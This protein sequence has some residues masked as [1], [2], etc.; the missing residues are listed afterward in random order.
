MRVTIVSISSGLIFFTSDAAAKVVLIEE[1]VIT[2]EGLYFWYPNGQKAFHYAPSISPRG[3]CYTI[4]NGYIFFGW[5]KGGMDQRD[6]MISRKKIGSGEWETVELPHKN[7]LI[8]PGAKWGESHNTITVGVSTKD[9]TIHIFYD[10]HNDPLKYIVSKKGTA[11][12]SDRDFKKSIF[13]PTRGHLAE[14]EPIRITYPKITENGLGDLIVNYRKGSAIGGNEM[15]HVYNGEQ[16]SR[17]KQVTRGSDQTVPESRKNYAYS[18]A[19]VFANGNVYYSFSVRWRKNKEDG[20]LNEGVYLAK[21]GPTMTDDWEDPSGKRHKLPIEDYAPFLVADPESSGGRGANGGPP[22][23]VS[24]QGDIVLG[25]RGRGS[26]NTYDFMYTRS[27][28]QRKFTE[29]RGSIK[30]GSFWGNR[31]FSVTAAR[32]GKI[33]VRSKTLEESDWKEELEMNTDIRFGSAVSKLVDGMLVLI[34]E[35]RSNQKTDRQKIHCY[36]FKIGEPKKVLPDIARIKRVLTNR[37]DGAKIEVELIDVQQGM[38]I[39][40]A[41]DRQFEIP[42]AVLCDEDIEFLKQWMAEKAP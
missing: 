13:E 14:G 4:A 32:D 7:T 15:V 27:A 35:D 24:E 38:L 11:F 22:L 39:C 6:L 33:T 42:V 9:D 8:G 26:A 18:P 10:H 25:F 40:F 23:A 20:V 2:N 41:K 36:A 29:S 19:P 3:D 34:V 28:G 30:I 31:M 12:I 16:W 37:E 21:C 17:A 5:Y 1:S